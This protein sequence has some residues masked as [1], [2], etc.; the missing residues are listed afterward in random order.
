MRI[1]KFICEAQGVVA[2]VQKQRLF[3]DIVRE[4]LD[5]GASLKP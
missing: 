2:S 4:V 5:V 3:P 1:L